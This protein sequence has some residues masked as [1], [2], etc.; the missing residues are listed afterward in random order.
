MKKLIIAILA[1]TALGGFTAMAEDAAK[2]GGDKPKHHKKAFEEVDTNKDGKISLDEFKAAI[3]KLDP[4]KAEEFFKKK[5]ANGDGSLSAD[6][7]NAEP[8][9]KKEAAK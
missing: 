1:L 2:Q 7:Y 4:A 5:D 8:K 9:H 6:E 3:P